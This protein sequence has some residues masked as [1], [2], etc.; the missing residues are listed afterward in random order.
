MLDKKG[1]QGFQP[2]SAIQAIAGIA[3]IEKDNHQEHHHITLSFS[4]ICI[5]QFTIFWERKDAKP[6]DKLSS[7]TLRNYGSVTNK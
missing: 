2:E 3:A 6:S 4:I 7:I 1:F 5:I